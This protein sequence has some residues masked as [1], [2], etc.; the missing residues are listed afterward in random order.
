MATQD[1]VT[2]LFES[3]KHDLH[4]VKQ[5]LMLCDSYI[6]SQEPDENYTYFESKYAQKLNEYKSKMD[7]TDIKPMCIT[8]Y[9]YNCVECENCKEN[10]YDISCYVNSSVHVHVHIYWNDRLRHNDCLITISKIYDK[11]ASTD[12][13]LYK[14]DA[15]TQYF[16]R[17]NEKYDWFR[18]E[19]AKTGHSFAD[20]SVVL[21][22]LCD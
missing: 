1:K 12:I 20:F 7:A 10:I 13:V 9:K 5:M 19:L 14:H 15:N 22:A 11:D 18:D 6:Q 4:S 2:E 8:G 17:L 21:Q 16:N 3:I